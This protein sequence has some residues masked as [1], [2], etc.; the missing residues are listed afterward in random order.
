MRRSPN[1][2]TFTRPPLTNDVFGSCEVTVTGFE[3]N[4]YIGPGP[5]DT[6]LFD[7]NGVRLLRR[8]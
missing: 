5:E 8:W 7:A 6:W 4:D 1:T 2:T 3:N